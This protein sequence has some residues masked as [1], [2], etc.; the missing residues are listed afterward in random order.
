MHTAVLASRHLWL[1]L[2]HLFHPQLLLLV[3]LPVPC[4]PSS[5]RKHHAFVSLA[6]S[7]LRGKYIFYRYVETTLFLHTY[8][9]YT[10]QQSRNKSLN[11]LRISGLVDIVNSLCKIGQY[12]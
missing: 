12:K 7:E 10:S 1:W 2:E 6:P 9:K 5:M 8:K 4:G 11:A 3:S